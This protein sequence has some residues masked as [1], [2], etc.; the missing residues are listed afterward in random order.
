M[1]LALGQPQTSKHLRVLSEAGLVTVQ[2]VA[3]R[4]IYGL[5]EQAFQKLGDW[6]ETFRQQQ[7]E[8]YDRLDAYLARSK[9]DE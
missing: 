8:R 9:G 4:R 6:L 2:P 7:S 5:H 3:N 1:G